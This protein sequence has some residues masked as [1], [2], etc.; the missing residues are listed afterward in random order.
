MAFPT[1]QAC[2]DAVNSFMCQSRPVGDILFCREFILREFQQ[3]PEER[4][5]ALQL[6]EPQC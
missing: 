2:A 1:S 5:Q 4:L 3:E 6:R